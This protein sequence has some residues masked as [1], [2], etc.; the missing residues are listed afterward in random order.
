MLFIQ[1]NYKFVVLNR[2]DAELYAAQSHKYKSIVISIYGSDEEPASIRSTP[3]N[4][5]KLVRFVRFD[6]ID[7]NQK[8]LVLLG[9]NEALSI[10]GAIEEAQFR[11]GVAGF[12]KIIVHCG[13][14]LS[15]SAA[16][17]AALMYLLTGSDKEIYNNPKY[18]CNSWVYRMLL[19][20]YEVLS[21]GENLD[22]KDTDLNVDYYIKLVISNMV[23]DRA[24]YMPVGKLD[25]R[26][27]LG[28][29]C[30]V[31]LY[32]VELDA[33]P[34]LSDFKGYAF[35]ISY[36]G[37]ANY[38]ADIPVTDFNI[39]H[40]A[41]ERN[42]ELEEQLNIHLQEIKGQM[43]GRPP[44]YSN[45]ISSC[46]QGSLFGKTGAIEDV[47]KRLLPSRETLGKQFENKVFRSVKLKAIKEPTS[48]TGYGWLSPDGVYYEVPFGKHTEYAYYI[49]VENKLL[50]KTFDNM[51]FSEQLCAEEYLLV[52]SP[53]IDGSY[54]VSGLGEP[55]KRQR[56]FL[57]KFYM[58][59]GMEQL[60]MKYK[61]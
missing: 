55:T 42:K 59:K 23:T 16:T 11:F 46:L 8:G 33:C 36:N 51:D 50:S 15:R 31:L 17:A 53:C 13:A 10:L 29:F 7:T 32:N 35:H 28:L 60:A 9:P 39:L 48:E 56:E 20:A 45:M 19:R 57:Y 43:V 61:K 21:T 25:R 52:N 12:D 3:S 41:R 26:T 4:N 54:Y 58:C 2:R 34:S 24:F 37:P 1:N 38:Y 5:I 44:F 27:A 40:I 14:G 18:R 22:I 47:K 30:I 49:L 6:D